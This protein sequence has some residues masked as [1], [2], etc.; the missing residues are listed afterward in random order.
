MSLGG[1]IGDSLISA[2][3]WTEQALLVGAGSARFAF[4]FLMMP[5]FSPKLMPAMV[6][7]SLIITF[8]LV[9]L[10]LPMQ[11]DP[12]VLSAAQWLALIGREAAAGIVI[13]LFYATFLWAMASAGEIIDAKTGATIAQIIDPVSGG[14]QSLTATLLG[15]FA[16]VT[17]VTAGGLT[18]LIGTLMVSYAA[19]PMGPGGVSLD[20][21]AVRLFQGEFGRFFLIAFVLATP[22]LMVLYII[23]LGMGLLN[24]FAQNFNV[25]MLSLSIK[26]ISAI[27]VLVMIL[28]LL[29]QLVVNELTSRDAVS[30]GML[31]RAGKPL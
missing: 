15:R 9:A 31:D 28:P 30:Q 18:M 25:F 1:A 29:G 3:P 6:R 20:L 24:R 16:Q 21:D 11:F 7:N 2:A 26:A 22:V 23:D 14:T 4:A 8:G 10:A 27:F 17:F 13:G 5:L 19:W 12:S